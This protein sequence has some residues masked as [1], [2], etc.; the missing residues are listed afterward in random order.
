MDGADSNHYPR[1]RSDS[2]MAESGKKPLAYQNQMVRH[3]LM[4]QQGMVEKWPVN[5]ECHASRRIKKV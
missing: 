3:K 2:A 5:R 4:S 1:E